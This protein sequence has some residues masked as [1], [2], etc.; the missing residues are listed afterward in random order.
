MLISSGYIFDG[1]E[2]GD[3]IRNSIN[4]KYDIVLANPPFGIKGLNYDTIKNDY[5]YIKS[6]SAVPLFL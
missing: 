3:S 1:L 4:K 2:K 6:S 5:L